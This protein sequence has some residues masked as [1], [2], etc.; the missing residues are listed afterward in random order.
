MAGRPNSLLIAIVAALATAG[1]GAGAPSGAPPSHSPAAN[2]LRVGSAIAAVRIAAT[3]DEREKG[4][5]GNV[6]LGPDE[7]MLF[8]F[9][10]PQTPSFWMKD[11]HVPLS[12]AFITPEGRISD[13]L[14]MSPDTLDLHAPHVPARMA[15]EMPAGWF[16]KR[17]VRPGDAVTLP[18]DIRLDTAR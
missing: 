3:P 13:I 18:A 1:C 4:L 10:E 17:A 16:A 6:S 9:P 8:I 11:T 14:E 15:L 12:I 5:S 7:G 2:K